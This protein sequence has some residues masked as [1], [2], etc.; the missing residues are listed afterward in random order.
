MSETPMLGLPLL[1]A[2]QAQKHVTHNEALLLLDGLVQL[3]V[4]S[5]QLAAPPADAVAGDQF[6]V[7][8]AATGDWQG[9]GGKLANRDEAGWRFFTP[10]RGW[11]LW[12]VDEDAL[13]VFDG[14]VWKPVPVAGPLDNLSRLG[15]AAAASD[16]NRLTVASANT[17]L[18]HAGGDHRLKINKA[19]AINTAALLFQDNWSGRAEIGLAGDD[20]FR[21]K[22][23]AN[24]EAWQEALSVNVSNGAVSFAG[25]LGWRDMERA[26]TTLSLVP[27]TLRTPGFWMADFV[28]QQLL[29]STAS[30]L[31]LRTP[32]AGATLMGN[33]TGGLAITSRRRLATVAANQAR[34]HFLPDGTAAGVLIE[35][36]CSYLN[37]Y[38]QPTIA[39]TPVKA[40]VADA[41]TPAGENGAWQTVATIGTAAYSGAMVNITSGLDYWLQFEIIM[42]D[43][44]APVPGG[45]TSG[46]IVIVLQNGALTAKSPLTGAAGPL[47]QGPFAGGK[48][49]IQSYITATATGSYR[50]GWTKY[51]AQ[52]VKNFKIGRLNVGQGR[53]PPSM[54]DNAT[55]TP[56]SRAGDSLTFPL[57]GVVGDEL[58][59]AA[60]IIAPPVTGVRRVVALMQAA[61]GHSLALEFAAGLAV[62]STLCTAD[63]TVCGTATAAA[64]LTTGNR[65]RLAA[66]WSA[67]TRRLRVVSSGG[68]VAESAATNWPAGLP[69]SVMVGH[70]NGQSQL[71][72]G[73]RAIAVLD[74]A[75][76]ASEML[77]WVAGS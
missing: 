58:T 27:P 67:A 63:G 10:R 53:Y 19:A 52:S 37:G 74:R 56:N 75:W 48:Y 59:L 8:A 45:A 32:E 9:Q 12:V 77:N 13:L 55:P 73:V 46:D 60:D 57:S 61:T 62:P 68:A 39:Q 42:D 30:G 28:N 11:R 31:T 22:V 71:G 41:A 7:A 49:V 23:S 70:D 72:A 40:G 29:A 16:D 54:F 34:Y 1:A 43:G 64:A 65:Y 66:A 3:S 17:L 20:N 6:I 21:I 25:Q 33:A 2:A 35:P 24:G 44:S 4:R 18:T 51:A 15:V 5:R 26:Q 69:V 47:I 50:F 36:P 76:S 14:A 38:S